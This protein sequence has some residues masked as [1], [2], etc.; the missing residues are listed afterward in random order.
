MRV[1]SVLVQEDNPSIC[2]R[3]P[4]HWQRNISCVT[5]LWITTE[6]FYFAVRCPNVDVSSSCKWEVTAVSTLMIWIKACRNRSFCG[7]VTSSFGVLNFKLSVKKEQ[8]CFFLCKPQ[9]QGHIFSLGP[10]FPWHWVALISHEASVPLQKCSPSDYYDDEKALRSR[11]AARPG[12]MAPLVTLPSRWGR[13]SL[14]LGWF[15]KWRRTFSW[16]K[17]HIQT[18]CW[19][20][21]RPCS[22]PLANMASRYDSILAQTSGMPS[23]V[24]EEAR[25][26]WGGGWGE[27]SR[28]H[29]WS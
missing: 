14:T 10:G 4:G 7:G 18:F 2:F 22:S 20:L 21:R 13:A 25:T 28:M 27:G 23:P 9:S 5:A 8:D 11:S 15:W 12:E 19:A 24:C 17:L 6:M 16:I 3:E 26:T 1:C 29:V